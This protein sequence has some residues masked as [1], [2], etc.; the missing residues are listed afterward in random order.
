LSTADVAY[1]GGS[2]Q[3][4]ITRLMQAVVLAFLAVKLAFIFTVG[5]AS[6]EV[7]YWMWGRV[8]ELS[9]FD[10]P[11]L[12]AWLLGLSY[13]VFGRSLFALRWLTLVSMLGTFWIFLIWAQRLS[14]RYWQSQFWVCVA[15]YLASPT[16]GFFGSVAFHDHLLI[17]LCLASG[18]CF[19]TYLTLWE[20][21]GKLAR[22]SLYLGAIVL[23]L[24]AL[25]KYSAIFLGLG[26]VGVILFNRSYRRLLA[27]PHL[28]LASI[29][30]VAMLTPVFI[31]NVQHAGAS[32]LFHLS[33]RHGGGYW[34]SDPDPSRF[35]E[36]P[37]TSL[38]LISPFIFIAIFR[39]FVARLEPGFERTAR[40]L[41]VWVFWLSTVT[42]LAVTLFDYVNWWWNLVAYIVAMP[43]ASRYMGRRWLLWLH[44]IYGA[45][46][47]ALL[48]ISTAIVPL[49][50]VFGGYDWRLSPLYGWEQ[51]EV[52]ARK[53]VDQF[54]PD[55]IASDGPELASLTGFA[56][57][58]TNVTSLDP[59]RRS[60]YDYWFDRPSHA[61]ENAVVVID[62]RVDPSA[63]SGYFATLTPIDSIDISRF[64][65]FIRGFR[66]YYGEGYNP[67]SA[68]P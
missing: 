34:F 32:F 35:W 65:V 61:G 21:Q 14:G 16:F 52:S 59:S 57:D 48:F 18:H 36:F 53:A 66:L 62:S 43:F 25:T 11:P 4:N 38:L 49:I 51:L 67:G 22:G 2:R 41:A 64:G 63:V 9:Y 40:R 46:V 55:F 68:A 44:I 1:S 42:F 15:I 45:I 17:F 23:G 20:T 6:D 37:L 8:P 24:A 3:L 56:I 28:Y 7:Y 30:S 31:W 12:Q 10:H 58:T 39:F 19:I 29:L 27:D 50:N 60:Q 33:D 5:P 26:L 47:T 54:Q 13:N